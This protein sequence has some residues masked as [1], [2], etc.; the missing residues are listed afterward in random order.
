[1]QKTLAAFGVIRRTKLK[2]KAIRYRAKKNNL[3]EKS[4]EEIE[5]SSISVSALHKE[6][7]IFYDQNTL[8]LSEENEKKR[9]EEI[10]QAF[11]GE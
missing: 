1:M 9:I 8:K 2:I 10:E 4:V 3:K 5:R 11:V 6:G 7:T